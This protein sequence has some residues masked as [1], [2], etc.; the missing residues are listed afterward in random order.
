M[1]AKGY[2][3]KAETGAQIFGLNSARS[4]DAVIFHA[5]TSRNRQGDWL[6]AGGRVLGVTATGPS[7]EVALSRSYEAVAGIRWDGMQYRRDIG[8]TEASGAVGAG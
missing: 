3:A 2:P 8:R 5:A 4:D 7:L 1:A 6:T